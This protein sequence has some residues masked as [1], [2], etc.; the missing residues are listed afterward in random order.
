MQ[1]PAALMPAEN[2]I[3]TPASRGLFL[4]GGERVQDSM[5][6]MRVTINGKIYIVS[7]NSPEEVQMRAQQLISEKT[8]QSEQK[9]D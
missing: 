6:K 2:V 7:G 3:K 9:E 5:Y 4:K 8:A 1:K